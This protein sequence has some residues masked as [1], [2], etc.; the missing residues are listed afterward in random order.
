MEHFFINFLFFLIFRHFNSIFGDHS[1]QME[2]GDTNAANQQ[3]K[4]PI[5]VD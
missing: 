4:T 5:V 1:G 3:L 2:N